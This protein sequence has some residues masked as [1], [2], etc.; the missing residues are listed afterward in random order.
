MPSNLAQLESAARKLGRLTNEV[1]FVGGS[2]LDLLVTDQAA[3]PVRATIDVDV[4]AEIATYADY[5]I[6]SERLREFGFS[7]DVREDAPLCR[8]VH[9]DLTLDVIP[10]EESVLGF[11][12]VWYRSALETAKPATLPS[13]AIIRLI[14]A[15][16]FLGTKMEAFRRRGDRDFF[17]SHDLEDFIAVVEGRESILAEIQAA[18]PDLTAYLAQATKDILAEPHFRDALPGYLP[19]DAISQQRVS[20]VIDRLQRM[21][22]RS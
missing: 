1:V 22:R 15:P 3:A 4:I 19:G 5:V 13:G 11:S 6:F 2:T 10:I 9:M 7:E 8:W 12:N 16:F 14:T 20:L 18:P 17:A 21:S